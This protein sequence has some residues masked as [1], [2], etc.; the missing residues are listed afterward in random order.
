MFVKNICILSSSSR[1][2]SCIVRL[3][4]RFFL[5]YFTKLGNSLEFMFFYSTSLWIFGLSTQ[6][7]MMLKCWYEMMRRKETEFQSD[8]FWYY[9]RKFLFSKSYKTLEFISM[10]TI[11]NGAIA[12][13]G[14]EK[15][16]LEDKSLIFLKLFSFARFY[17]KIL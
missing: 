5:L 3:R 12:W 8:C 6:P 11:V 14:N 17:F 15:L 4:N 10:M 1:R 13:W 16:T 2:H 7:L 9:K